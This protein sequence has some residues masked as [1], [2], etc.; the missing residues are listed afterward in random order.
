[1]SLTTPDIPDASTG[2]ALPLRVKLPFAFDAD[3]LA[4]EALAFEESEWIKHFNHA[5]YEGDWCLVP[6]RS[7]YG[8]LR[9]PDDRYGP[10]AGYA[11]P[12]AL[13]RD[14]QRS[15]GTRL[16][17]TF[18]PSAEAGLRCAHPRT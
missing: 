17:N 6:L 9:T 12:R 11:V 3:A 8:Q 13:S 2:E 1:V 16:R 7:P 14:T 5:Y 18:R 15:R 10:M 4:G